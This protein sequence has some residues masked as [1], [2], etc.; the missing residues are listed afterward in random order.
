MGLWFA[1]LAKAKDGAL[2][3]KDSILKA[4]A[5]TSEV[6]KTYLAKKTITA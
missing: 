1:R 6:N 3:F 2:T 4:V 5:T